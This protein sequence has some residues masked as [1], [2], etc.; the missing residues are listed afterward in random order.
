MKTKNTSRLWSF[1][2]AILNLYTL[3]VGIVFALAI[4][5]AG[6]LVSVIGLPLLP[7]NLGWPWWVRV[8][9]EAAA[10]LVPAMLLSRFYRRAKK[11]SMRRYLLTGWI[12]SSA[13][14]F[15][16]ILVLMYWIPV[17]MDSQSGSWSVHLWPLAIPMA[18]LSLAFTV[19]AG[20]RTAPVEMPPKLPG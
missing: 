2:L 12:C 5:I 6:A 9:L 8:A 16:I 13:F 4:M 15:G 17:S 10:F 20:R 3:A 18:L 1:A 7:V 11:P 19:D 14:H